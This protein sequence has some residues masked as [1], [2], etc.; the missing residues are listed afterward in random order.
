ME[1]FVQWLSADQLL[2]VGSDA[3]REQAGLCG[4]LSAPG[5]LAI[6]DLLPKAL[7][8]FHFTRST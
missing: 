1:P 5:C 7:S 4:F 3:H 6:E 2:L 8:L